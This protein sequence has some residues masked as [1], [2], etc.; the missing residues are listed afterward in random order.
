MLPAGSRLT[1]RDEFASV[2]RRGRRSGR[3][4]LV[5]HICGGAGDGGP[6]AGFVVSRAVGNAV[7][8][9]RV[10]RRLR[11]LVAPRLQQLPSDALLVVRA[12]PPA[13]DASSA[14]LAEDLDAGLRSAMRKL[15]GSPR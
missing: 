11:H 14:E 12:L 10:T 6:R 5:V 7:V 4:R 3:S 9:H 8:R 13:A 2:V 1:R 15:S